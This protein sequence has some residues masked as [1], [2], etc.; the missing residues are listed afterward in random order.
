MTDFDERAFRQK[1]EGSLD[2]YLY[3]IESHAEFFNQSFYEFQGQFIYKQADSTKIFRLLSEM[4]HNAAGV[5]HLLWP[6]QARNSVRA[7]MAKIRAELLLNALGL[8]GIDHPLRDRTGR[9]HLAHLDERIDD[10]V[11][12]SERHNI[13]M[14]NIGPKDRMIVGLEDREMFEHFDTETFT[15]YFRGDA[16]QVPQLANGVQD[17]RRRANEALA[18]RREARVQRPSTPSG[19]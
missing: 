9:D 10:W 15:F 2:A 19:S 5:S 14:R 13:A 7:Q 1:V 11:Q 16:F 4:L 3:Q 6:G 12:T 17:V 8:N 18:K